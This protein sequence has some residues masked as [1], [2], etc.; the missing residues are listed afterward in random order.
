MRSILWSL[1]GQ[2]LFS[3]IPHNA[4]VLRTGIL[5]LFGMKCGKRVRVRKNVQ[6]DKPWNII[7]DDLVIFGEGAI[8][9]ASDRITI[10]KR[11][12]ISQYAM[13]VTESGDCSTAGRT[14]RTGAI[15]I[16]PDCW[17]AT[18]AVVMPGSFIEDGVI[19]G[20]RSL[21]DGR[22][23]EWKVCTG[24]PAQPRVDRVLHGNR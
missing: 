24:E 20:A 2:P 23:P 14:K 17:I 12:V 4:Y 13:L 11:S 1:V 10:G 19:V 3:C 5:K 6:F 16:C 9:C 22:L 8:V 21:V 7:A 18:D 15:T